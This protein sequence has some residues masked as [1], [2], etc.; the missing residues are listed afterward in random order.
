METLLLPS[1]KVP[2]F[3][4]TINTDFIQ[5]FRTQHDTIMKNM[6]KFSIDV[7]MIKTSLNVRPGLKILEIGSRFG[8]QLCELA[9]MGV[10]CYD[11]DIVKGYT[12]IVDHVAKANGLNITTTSGDACQMPYPEDYFDGIYAFSTFEHIW[13]KE[14]AFRE[15]IRVLKPGA[16]LLIAEGNPLYY[17]NFIRYCF[18][19]YFSSGGER[20]GLTWIFKRDRIVDNYQEYGKGRDEDVHSI[21]WWMKYLKRYP[22]LKPELV[23]TKFYYY[24][25]NDHLRKWIY[26]LLFPI[27]PFLG[28]VLVLVRKQ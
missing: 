28:G 21:F 26:K 10:E 11:I 6:S 4:G 24:W 14:T 12:E 8:F 22:E 9:N 5:G 2:Q 19:N 20:G 15:C 25:K 27:F 1:L 3:P 17:R 16:R 23:A 13:N 7:E 18:N